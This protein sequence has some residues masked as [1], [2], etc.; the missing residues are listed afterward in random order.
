MNA[1]YGSVDLEP[2]WCREEFITRKTSHSKW[3]KNGGSS[4]ARAA[5][6]TGCPMQPTIDII[7]SGEQCKAPL[8]RP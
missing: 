2:L 6:D 1:T 4:R 5:G 7:A 3:P 8:Y